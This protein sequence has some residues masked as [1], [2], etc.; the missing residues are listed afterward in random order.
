MSLVT[1]MGKIGG[2]GGGAAVRRVPVMVSWLELVHDKLKPG[3]PEDEEPEHELVPLTEG[4][5]NENC[6]VKGGHVSVKVPPGVGTLF[7]SP[8]TIR[9]PFDEI[10]PTNSGGDGG[11]GLAVPLHVSV[12]APWVSVKLPW[13][14]IVAD[15][16]VVE[17]QVVEPVGR[18]P[19]DAPEQVQVLLLVP[20]VVPPQVPA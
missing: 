17:L 3:P 1:E 8:A 4:G 15:Q 19:H 20:R 6:T 11:F 7:V 16:V 10:V 5:D 9:M 12:P 13:E 2:G 18:L 14:S